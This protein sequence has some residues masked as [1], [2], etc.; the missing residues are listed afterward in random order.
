MRAGRIGQNG[1]DAPIWNLSIK[2]PALSPEGVAQSLI[3][4]RVT[5]SIS[6]NAAEKVFC[7]RQPRMS[8]SDQVGRIRRVC[9]ISA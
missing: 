4:R 2:Q 1:D 5:G 6:Q 3:G 7:H 8:V 9:N